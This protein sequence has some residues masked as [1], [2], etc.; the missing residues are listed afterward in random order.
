M[1]PFSEHPITTGEESKQAVK[2]IEDNK[3]DAQNDHSRDKKLPLVIP[4]IKRNEWKWLEKRDGVVKITAESADNNNT[5]T[6]KNE[7]QTEEQKL[8]ERAKLEL[9]KGTTLCSVSHEK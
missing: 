9:L 5:T 3:T 4:M 7:P 8:R 1:L 6:I 2:V